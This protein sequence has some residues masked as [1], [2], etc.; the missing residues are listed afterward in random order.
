MRVVR[1]AKGFSAV[2]LSCEYVMFA[3]IRFG[4]KIASRDD[5]AFAYVHNFIK[6]SD[7]YSA[8]N[9]NWILYRS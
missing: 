6:T 1:F 2:S 3:G 4:E 5:E 7:G 8:D 9:D